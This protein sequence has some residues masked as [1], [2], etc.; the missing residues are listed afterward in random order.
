MEGFAEH[1]KMSRN[2]QINT[3]ECYPNTEEL[4]E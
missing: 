3:G 2:E 1:R 4:A